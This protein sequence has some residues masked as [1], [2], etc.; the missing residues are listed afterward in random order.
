MSYDFKSTEEKWVK[1]W[2][3]EKIFEANVAKDK[4]K[5]F[6]TFPFPYMNGPLHLGHAF[7]STRVDVY[8]R[9]KRMRGANVLFPWAWHITGEPI[10][11]AAERVRKGDATQIKIF[12][13]IDEVPEAEL[14]KFADAEYIARYYIRESR[15]TVKRL[16]HGIDWRR[17]FTTTSL[18]EQFNKFI[19]WQYLTLRK[20]GYVVKGTHP[21][22]WCPN[23]RSPTG[24]HDRL[25]GEGA[26]PVEFILL[27]FKFDGA[28]L[29][30]ATLRPETIFGV[31]N[32]WINPEATYA[33]VKVDGE[34][35]IVS[36]EAVAKLKEQRDSVMALEEFKGAQ[37]IGKHCTHPLSQEKILILPASFVNP[38]N[39]TGVVMSVP[40]HAPYDWIALRDLINAPQEAEKFGVSKEKLASI[41]PVSLIATEGLGEHPAV[42]II[43]KMQV[44]DQQDRKVEEAT[45][46]IY[47]EEF[48]K[49]V[50]KNNTGKYAGM[51]V[52][53]TKKL[54]VADFIAQGIAE[55]MHELSEE[56]I[57]RCGTA[58]V[59]KILKD[60]WFLNYADEGWKE[61]ARGALATMAIYPPEARA[62]FEYTIDWL[63]NKACARKTGLGTPLPW[64]REWKVETLSDSTVYMAFYTIAKSIAQ[65]K[66]R[67]EQLAPEVFDY[68][69]YGEGDAKALAKNHGIE[70][71]ILREMREEFE[72]F[73]P[74][75]F[76][77]SAKE[78]IPNHLTFFIFHHVALFP[79]EKWPRSIGVNGMI[80][81]EGEKMSKSK[82]NFI[83][84]KSA[85]RSYGS[86]ATRVTLLY[87]SEGMRDPDW[88]AR[89]A[90]DTLGRISAFY[91]LAMQIIKMKS[92]R[93]NV[94][95]IDSWLLSKLQRRI[96]RA[97]EDLE[98]LRTRG[99]LQAS[100]FDLWQDVKW[101]MRRVEPNRATLIQVLEA[102]IKMLSPYMP[103]LCEELWNAMGN[104][105]Y[106]ALSSWP[107]VEEKLINRSAELAEEMI[108]K[109][110]ED[111]AN[112]LQLRGI[113]PKKLV[114]Y[115]A[116]RWKWQVYKI[117]S[118][119][120][121]QM[122]RPEMKEIMARCMAQPELKK[123]GGEIA[124]YVGEL[125]KD[126]SRQKFE[127]EVDEFKV[128]SEAKNFFEKEFECAVEIYRAEQSDAYDPM[129]KRRNAAPLKPAIYVE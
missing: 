102:W 82:G 37:L 2:N 123:L 48:Y 13:E 32:M 50:L 26:S 85:L 116:P 105:S 121:T 100:F 76:R 109:T 95:G 118:E 35:L 80:S 119:A 4:P 18:H 25:Q 54:L 108:E 40:S 20:K 79:R 33:R 47:R 23:C 120:A 3:E 56:V 103:A 34:T 57:C 30:A 19:E 72:Y 94:Q 86:D 16:G 75:D 98:N 65:H 45:Q 99:A 11:G 122:Q 91:E 49:G 114:F 89:A 113:K 41:K 104:K 68:I 44:K 67:G 39:A 84:L 38:K 43:E 29:P 110:I 10:A 78:L 77:N 125:L 8:A 24:D 73:M 12:R 90:Q 60:Q 69:F 9:F 5:T 93:T 97:T 71:K 101:Y 106:V 63:E 81:I 51:R 15:E 61:K 128:L 31:T 62:N 74:L 107:K 96:A 64:D 1:K 6:V 14:K 36:R 21:V 7:T 58:N 126:V 115:T 112:I 88:R 53:E 66:I 52:A 111:A 55:K 87:S 129:N 17:E 22:V 28:F 83:T 59:V 46:M 127:V 117:A 27:K 42:D 92:S 124:K 70:E